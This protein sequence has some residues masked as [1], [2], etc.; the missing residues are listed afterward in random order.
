[1]ENEN[2]FAIF[3]PSMHESRMPV[4]FLAGPIQGAVNW[5]EEAIRFFVKETK[6]I[7]IA[8]PR[9]MSKWHGDYNAQVD[10]ETHYLFQAGDSGGVFFWLAKEETHYCER[11]HAQTSRFELGEWFG[12]SAA[13]SNRPH[14]ELGIEEGFTNE[15][16][17]R[18]RVERT[19]PDLKIHSSLA[20]TCEAM[21]GRFKNF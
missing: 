4:V 1:M 8:C 11:P 13:A 14:F 10:W 3:P 16:Y 9:S 21:A 19:F 2:T 12:R 5:Q 18:R 6:G 17:I 7:L 15:K 20:D